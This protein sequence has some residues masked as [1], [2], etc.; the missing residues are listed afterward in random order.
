MDL[1]PYLW[2]LSS[3]ESAIA[4][5]LHGHGLAESAAAGET[6]RHPL[7]L[8]GQLCAAD[9]GGQAT[10]EDADSDALQR[11]LD[12]WIELRAAALGA[13]SESLGIPLAE[14]QDALPRLGP[15]LL[16]IEGSAGARGLLALDRRG[17]I[18]DPQLRARRI[19]PAV[20]A[21][22]LAEPLV[23]PVRLD[24]EGLL[25]AA[26]IPDHRRD[27][28]RDALI[29]RRLGDQRVGG[30]W[31]LRRPPQ[32]GLGRQ[33]V[34][35]GVAGSLAAL[36]VAH[37]AHYTLLLGSWWLIGRGALEGHS[38]LGWIAAWALMLLS[39]IPLA[40]IQSWHG[41]LAAL[42]LGSV[43]KRRLL[44]GALALNPDE[45]RTRGVGRLLAMVIEA[46][47]VEGL[48]LSSGLIAATALIDLGAAAWVLGQGAG[49][50]ALLALLALCVLL[51]IILARHYAVVRGL[52]TR[53]RMSMTH[54]LVERMVGH[55]T[56]LAQEAPGGWHQREDRS[57][58]AYL[59]RSRELDR[60]ATLVDIFARRGWIFVGFIGLGSALL[61]GPASTSL[62]AVTFG[63]LL[64]ARTGFASLASGLSE[65]IDLAIAWREVRPLVHAGARRPASPRLVRAETRPAA[66]EE[67]RSNPRA[68]QTRLQT[69]PKTRPRSI[70]DAR[71]LTY[72]YPGRERPALKSASLALAAG[73]RVLLQGP[74]GGGKSTFAAV[75]A[76]LRAPESGLL[77]VEGLDAQTH[78]ELGWRE[79]VAAA[80]QFHHN[81]VLTNTF[82]FNLLMGRRWPPTAEDLE[83]GRSLCHE[84]GLGPLL[85]R[86]PA[87]MQQSVGETGW[88]LSHGE[89][90]RLF[91]ARALL[92]DADL[93]ILDE[94]F[95]ALDP[96]SQEMAL[97]CAFRHARTLMVIAHP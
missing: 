20:L 38:D 31:Q 13:E 52:W 23:A 14:L 85:A 15:A 86:M 54:A 79:R 68:D 93:V 18:L 21:E 17:R 3:A 5:L 9:P 80:P 69:T 95:A 50:P 51:L 26:G 87:G 49:A 42:R 92:Q 34:A 45:L 65:L 1:D 78:G 73:D 91:L 46:E 84:L 8:P 94:S 71:A 82:A 47:A 35:E 10:Q 67:R 88:Q 56:R 57:T 89:R 29:H 96:D 90:S 60:V 43:L 41:G 70:L 32:A 83:L 7:S 59:R 11:R 53:E 66:R 58:A 62:L 33:L 25:L 22:R 74:S 55:T 44:A 36:L 28:A 37:T 40:L 39:M 97:T 48:A 12:R 81:H 61:S 77:L 75:L 72:R 27:R 76:G 4:A 24:C 16:L 64:L 19:A 30:I 2:P 63:G 6:S